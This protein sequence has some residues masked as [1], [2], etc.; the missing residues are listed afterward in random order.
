MKKLLLLLCIASLPLITKAQTSQQR[1]TL[2]PSTSY[3]YSLGNY[4]LPWDSLKVRYLANP[5]GSLLILDTANISGYLQINNLEAYSG[6]MVAIRDT[7]RTSLTMGIG[8]L[9]GTIDSALTIYSGADYGGIH[10]RGGLFSGGLSAL[11]LSL[12]NPLTVANGGTGASTLTGLLQGNG[13]S[14]ITAI[15]NSSTVGQVLRVTGASTYAWGALDL[16]DGDAITGNLPVANLNSGTDASASTFWRGDGTWASPVVA[17]SAGGWTNF[18]PRVYTTN[19]G[20]TVYIRSSAGDTVGGTFSGLLNVWGGIVSTGVIVAPGIRVNGAQILVTSS[21]GAI[22]ELYVAQ[23]SSKALNNIARIKLGLTQNPTDDYTIQHRQLSSSDDDSQIEFLAPDGTTD[24]AW[25]RTGKFSFVDS[26]N[27]G[28]L[29]ASRLVASDAS[30]NLVSTITL[31]NL[32]SS[33][34][35]VTGTTG[36]GNLML[37]ASPTTTGTLTNTVTSGLNI[38]LYKPAGAAIALHKTNVTAQEWQIAGEDDFKVYDITDAAMVALQI[39]KGTQA[40]T[41]AGS[42]TTGDNIYVPN[43]AGIFTPGLESGMAIRT[44]GNMEWY[45]GGGVKMNLSTVGNLTVSGTGLSKTA[46]QWTAADTIRSGNYTTYSYFIPGGALVQSSSEDL[47][48]NIRNFGADLS[49]F[50]LV[51]PRKYNFKREAFI[52]LFDEST[53]PDSLSEREKGEIR[54]KFREDNLKEADEKSKREITGFL[55]EEF[56]AILGKDS[57]E[58]NTMELMAVMWLKIQELEARIK[59]LEK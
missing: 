23:P 11:T 38:D 10:A 9:T 4:A 46:G 26:I 48:T 52:R 37:S 42:I 43:T 3:G 25:S 28:G 44:A 17:G 33:I 5:G 57:K 18:T 31:A 56:N 40:V 53:L 21:S 41:V 2:V 51:K 49:K 19:A 35:D 20:D 58:I 45:Q 29:T 14:A 1:A 16:A 27:I 22:N 13:T 59:K 54:K 55:A 7:A 15:T 47:K 36:T 6:D 30:K 32:A 24:L 12:T 50:S 34:S 39:T 8:S